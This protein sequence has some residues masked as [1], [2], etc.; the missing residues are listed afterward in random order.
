MAAAVAVPTESRA[1]GQGVPSANVLQ[2]LET[3]E[4]R[5]IRRRYCRTYRRCFRRVRVRRICR[6]YRRCFTRWV[7]YRRPVYRRFCRRYYRYGR[8]TT[9]YYRRNDISNATFAAAGNGETAAQPVVVSGR[10]FAAVQSTSRNGGTMTQTKPD[11]AND[12]TEA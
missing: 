1:E 8:F 5:W 12:S 7:T 3:Q 2:Q 11:T 9:R 4:A 10:G 6:P